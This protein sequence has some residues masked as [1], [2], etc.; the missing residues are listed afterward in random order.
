MSYNVDSTDIL[1]GALTMK[2]GK[3]LV[4]RARR[5]E[6]PE[7]CPLDDLP[8]D[9]ALRQH[10]DADVPLSTFWWAGQFSGSSYQDVL[11]E[12]VADTQ[13]AADI[14]FTWESGDS[15]SGIRIKDGKFAEHKV[16]MALGDP[17]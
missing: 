5:D 8:S 3:I 14:L 17:V 9:E 2:A 1:S 10:L 11:G 4:W 7:I 15:F 6:L 13:G 12:F 16:V